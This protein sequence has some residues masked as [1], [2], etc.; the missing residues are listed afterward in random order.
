MTLD[1]LEALAMK[2]T[3]GPWTAL[4]NLGVV[5]TK[6]DDLKLVFPGIVV[7]DLECPPEDLRFI[8]AARTALPKLLAVART[9]ESLAHYG[10]CEAPFE[11]CRHCAV[12]AALAALE[13]T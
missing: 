5:Q 2:A 4:V 1:E 10:S 12:I 9:A 8:A 3:P 11:P 6:Q 13:A 7:K